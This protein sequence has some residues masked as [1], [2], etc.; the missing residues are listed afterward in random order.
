MCSA[1]E[2]EPFCDVET[3]PFTAA[4]RALD[5]GDCS[6]L[7]LERLFRETIYASRGRCY[8]C[9][10]ESEKDTVPE[11]RH[12]FHQSGN[13]DE[14]SL[15]TMREVIDAGLVDVKDPLRSLLLLEPLAEGGGGVPH[16]GHEKFSPGSDPGYDN[17]VYWLRRYAACQ[18]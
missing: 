17:F 16:G 7:A 11:A 10:F 14:S 6:E 15:E 1:R 5:S 8:P 18:S 12:F 13:C 2:H 9:H 4:N 3:E